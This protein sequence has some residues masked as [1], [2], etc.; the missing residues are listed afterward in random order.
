MLAWGSGVPWPGPWSAVSRQM[1]HG[2][3][4][5]PPSLRAGASGGRRRRNR[6]AASGRLMQK[7]GRLCF[8]GEISTAGRKKEQEQGGSRL[9]RRQG[10]RRQRGATEVGRA[11][12]RPPPCRPDDG[13]P[14]I[15][16]L[17]RQAVG[18]SWKRV[19][20]GRRRP[21]GPRI[22]GA[23]TTAVGGRGQRQPRTVSACRSRRW[24]PCP[25]RSHS[26]ARR[27]GQAA[28]RQA[29]LGIISR[30][31]PAVG[32]GWA[33]SAGLRAGAA[34]KGARARE[35]GFGRRGSLS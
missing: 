35:R 10:S 31:K 13:W 4:P 15:R 34:V 2:Q 14:S 21:E 30:A 16:L 7:T 9:R 32:F 20:A 23:T 26:R 29:R 22:K 17:L 11:G 27:L 19:S 33:E 3:P 28:A 18:T 24:L 5:L 1:G 6:P 8:G 12:R 25:A